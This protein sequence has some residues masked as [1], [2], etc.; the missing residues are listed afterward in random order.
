MESKNNMNKEVV[1]YKIM[2]IDEKGY[3]TLFHGVNGSRIMPFDTWIQAE[4][5]WGGEG[6]S[7]YWTGFHV[8]MT[9]ELC[10][11]YFKKFTDEKKTR[12]IVKCFAKN[13]TPKKSSRG[14]V[15]LAEW[16]MIPSDQKD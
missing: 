2:D 12:V 3:K 9:R 15:F 1:C 5:K 16:L 6:G 10:L 11:K 8:L 13:L 14:M 4:R 7:K